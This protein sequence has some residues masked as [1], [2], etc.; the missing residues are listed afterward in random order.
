MAGFKSGGSGNATSLQGEPVSS[1]VPTSGQS[2][3]FT[4]GQWTPQ[5]GSAAGV[6]SLSMGTTGLTPNTATTGAITVAGT[7]AIAN[8]GTGTTTA[9][10]SGSVVLATSP[11]MT[12]PNI[13]AATA[14]SVNGTTIPT[15]ATLVTQGGALGT[16]ASGTLTN[17]TGLPL[18]TGVTGTLGT[19]NGGT[20]LTTVGS[21][22]QVLTSNGS[23]LSWQTPSGGSSTPNAASGSLPASFYASTATYQ[24]IDPVT[25]AAAGQGTG[26]SQSIAKGVVHYV[27]IYLPAGVSPTTLTLNIQAATAGTTCYAGLYNATTQI[28]FTGSFVGSATGTIS[29]T[30]T[31]TSAGSLTSLAAGVYFVAILVSNSSTGA[32]VG[33][34]ATTQSPAGLTVPFGPAAAANTLTCQESTLGSA[35]TALPGTISGTPTRQTL[36]VTWVGVQ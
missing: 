12:T 18:T 7:L 3:V 14:T 22:G 35:L 29:Q 20:G 13:G 11:V 27:A 1:T 26:T 23:S 32:N 31:A 2:L 4:S 36:Y 15:L 25:I 21:N 34:L 9:T 10:G 28:G 5:T 17:A 8:G 16:P 24:N 33:F 6:A 19:T 30:M